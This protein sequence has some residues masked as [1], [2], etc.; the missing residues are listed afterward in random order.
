MAIEDI[1][2]KISA[3]HSSSTRTPYAWSFA[4]RAAFLDAHPDLPL[5]AKLVREDDTLHIQ[6]GEEG[7]MPSALPS[8]WQWTTLSP[9]WVINLHQPAGYQRSTLMGGI[10]DDELHRIT[11]NPHEYTNLMV[12]AMS[13]VPVQPRLSEASDRFKANRG[14]GRHRK[15]QP[16]FKR[17]Q[18]PVADDEVE[19]PLFNH[20]RA[21][22]NRERQE[23]SALTITTLPQ[24]I[25]NW[26]D[27]NVKAL[28]HLI[29]DLQMKRPEIVFSVVNGIV[30]MKK[31]M[32]EDI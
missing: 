23:S 12:E 16:L 4:V 9:L 29:M 30:T 1:A 8:P 24:T 14:G 20:P 7:N 26:S 15:T 10:Y 5:R 13:D 3:K 2:V 19:H 18:L 6:Y 32:L 25:A 27:A 31:Q 21:V 22:A 11:I 28:R 17:A